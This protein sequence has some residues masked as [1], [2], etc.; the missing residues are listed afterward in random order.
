[1]LLLLTQLC[2]SL[3]DSV[4]QGFSPLIDYE[5]EIAS[6][7]QI[8]WND[9]FGVRRPLDS[10]WDQFMY[11]LQRA[12]FK[13]Q[14][15]QAQ[16]CFSDGIAL[17][18]GLADVYS[19]YKQNPSLDI[20]YN[21]NDVFVGFNTKCNLFD[22]IQGTVIMNSLALV[23][24]EIPIVSVGGILLRI[25]DLASLIMDVADV[26]FGIR[27]LLVHYEMYNWGFLA[28]KGAKLLMQAYMGGWL[29]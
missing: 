6:D 28:G 18:N 3:Q 1:M 25:I 17:Y 2:G 21:L 24:E 9:V 27:V 12:G 5:E 23:L 22:T 15:R 8:L 29:V 26:G 19:T 14:F 10:S 16:S 4:G 13:T 7:L 20:L 11:G